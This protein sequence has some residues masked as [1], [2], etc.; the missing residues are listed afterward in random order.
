MSSGSKSVLTSVVRKARKNPKLEV[1]QASKEAK[2]VQV[3]EAKR[4]FDEGRETRVAE[5]R[6][7]HDHYRSLRKAKCEMDPNYLSD[8]YCSGCETEFH[9]HVWL[10][11]RFKDHSICFDCKLIK[12]PAFLESEWYR[13]TE[14]DFIFDSDSDE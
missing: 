8:E 1:K 13:F 2:L 11:D 3:A 14:D 10:E 5:A 4:L 9:V 7:L 12:D 6:R